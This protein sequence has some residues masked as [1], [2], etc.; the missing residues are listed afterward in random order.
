VIDDILY[1]LIT[2]V[3]KEPFN[4]ESSMVHEVIEFLKG[5]AEIVFKWIPN[6]NG[7]LSSF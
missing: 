2:R 4:F 6:L 5:P 7:P 3:L 1:G